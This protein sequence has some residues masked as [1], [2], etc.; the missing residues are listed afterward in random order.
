M[1]RLV[2]NLFLLLEARIA[3]NLAKASALLL[4]VEVMRELNGTNIIFKYLLNSLEH[5]PN[6]VQIIVP[7]WYV[8]FFNR[9]NAGIPDTIE[10]IIE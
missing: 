1:I 7:I 10:I 6:C 9:T 8:A 3:P 5:E 2:R 4:I